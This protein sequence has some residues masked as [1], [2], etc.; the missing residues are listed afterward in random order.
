MSSRAGGQED[1]KLFV[2]RSVGYIP[3]YVERESTKKI[4]PESA[5]KHKC[6]FKTRGRHIPGGVVSQDPSR[7]HV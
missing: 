4:A 3:H 6:I 7:I 1:K 5:G 2:C